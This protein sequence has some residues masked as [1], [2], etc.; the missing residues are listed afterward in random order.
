MWYGEQWY[1]QTIAHMTFKQ[2]WDA[3]SIAM[4]QAAPSKKPVISHYPPSHM[5]DLEKLPKA[6]ASRVCGPIFATGDLE[7]QIIRLEGAYVSI[8]MQLTG[9]FS[10]FF[11]KC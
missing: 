7:S 2:D 1:M 5:C 4:L 6:P 8:P 3:I 10:I 11:R 9:K